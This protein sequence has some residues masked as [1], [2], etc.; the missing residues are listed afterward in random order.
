MPVQAPTP[1]ANVLTRDEARARAG[2]LSDVSY[3][4]HLDLTEQD[5]SF[6]SDT[7]VRFRCAQPGASTFIDL[8]VGE[9]QNADGSVIRGEAEHI[10]LNGRTLPLDAHQRSAA[11]IH[12]D[13]LDSYNELRVGARCLY[14]SEGVGLHRPSD[15]KDADYLHTQF[16]PFEAHRVFACFD[17]PDLKARFS[18]TVAAPPGWEVISC[19]RTIERPTADGGAFRFAPTLPIPTYATAVVTGPFH[20]EHRRYER[21][22]REIELGIYCR[23]DDARYLD[24]DEIAAITS[25][26]FE[27]YEELFD[28]PY[29]FDKYDQLFVPGFGYG[30][31]ENVGCVVLND[32]YV[33][34]S[35][36]TGADRQKRAET[37]LHE[38]AHMWFGDL[39]TMRWWDDLWLNE[40]FASF[41]SYLALT[42]ATSF[43]QAW[44][45]FHY[46]KTDAYRLD[47]MPTTHPVVDGDVDDTDSVEE[48]FDAITYAKGAA[49][50][51]QLMEWVGGDDAFFAGVRNY[52]QRY[53]FANTEFDDFLKAVAETSKEPLA[54][55]PGQWLRR[56]GVNRLAAAFTPETGGQFTSFDIRQD[57][58]PDTAPRRPHSVGVGLYRQQDGHLVADDAEPVTVSVLPQ[59]ST[60]VPA[61]VGR[62]VPDLVLVNDGDRTY[63][64]ITLD[65]RSLST[66]KAD[67]GGLDDPLTR[68]V[69]WTALWDMVRQANPELAARRYLDVALAQLPRETEM[70]SLQVLL[71]AQIGPPSAL[72]RTAAAV[73]LYGDPANRDDARGRLTEKA[74]EAMTAAPPGS[75]LQLVWAQAFA[76]A[77]RR[78]A[79][80]AELRKMLDTGQWLDGLEVDLGLRWLIVESLAA[81]GVIDEDVIAAQLHPEDDATWRRR[82]EAALAARPTA[83]AKEDAWKKIIGSV[84][85]LA[86]TRERMRGFLQ[87][88]QDDVLEPYRTRYFEEGLVTLTHERGRRFAE[89]MY[90]LASPETVA[91]TKR[92]LD[93][94]DVAPAIRRVLEESSDEAERVLRARAIDGQSAQG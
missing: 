87:P 85:D 7:T 17:Q 83:A 20:A 55:W 8:L 50:L 86:Y 47:Q 69:C 32:R 3:E 72:S 84:D 82:K 4:I 80:Q 91:E 36:V 61:M 26:G 78:D 59:P 6:K 27:F 74:R 62:N 33:F 37:I 58:A 12:V 14:T 34:R 81:A 77:T 94:T 76:Y 68:A 19:G 15:P 42:R 45:A 22:G 49:A 56:A 57:P 79:D 46:W 40:A 65:S 1:V 43:T 51:R 90:P 24:A 11:R 30:A 92:F 67:L 10:E 35:R 16:E 48:N 31:M 71:P 9:R 66:L 5:V 39:V 54:E 2:L 23:P 38:L 93:S 88:D 75:D 73:L 89:A 41:A 70:A 18:F 21:N 60:A 52:F 63:A 25:A 44:V 29:P 64:N 53:E 28:Y 13:G